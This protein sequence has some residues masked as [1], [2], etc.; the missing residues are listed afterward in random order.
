MP[1][2][3]HRDEQRPDRRRFPRG[4]RRAGDRPGRHPY[5]LIADSY[6]GARMPCARYLD[7]FGFHVEEAADGEEVLALV[8]IAPPHVIVVELGLPKMPARRLARWLAQNWRT[9]DIPVIVL[10]DEAHGPDEEPPP[11][12]AGM[13]VKPFHLATMLEEIRRVIRAH[14]PL[15]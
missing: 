13:L 8:N 14:T 6:P 15:A 5:V 10:G 11:T 2:T 3:E 12:S 7:R 4:G 9:R 1:P